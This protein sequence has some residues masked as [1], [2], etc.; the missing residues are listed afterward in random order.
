MA[1]IL[2]NYQNIGSMNCVIGKALIPK[3]ALMMRE[4]AYTG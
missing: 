1:V 3:N 2:L 4:K